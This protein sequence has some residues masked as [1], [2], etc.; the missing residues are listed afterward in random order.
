MEDFKTEE[1]AEI[2]GVSVDTAKIR[3]HRAPARLKQELEK[4]CSFYR[5]DRNEF[6]CQPK[7][8]PTEVKK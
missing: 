5:D 3:L 7:E 2:I 4:Q 1:I 8:T 6:A